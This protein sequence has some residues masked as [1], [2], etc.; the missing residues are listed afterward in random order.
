MRTRAARRE[1][2]ESVHAWFR[3]P[4][5]RDQLGQPVAPLGAGSRQQPAWT[6][7]RAVGAS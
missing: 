2:L 4:A 5:E 1:G 3:D 6:R 7:A